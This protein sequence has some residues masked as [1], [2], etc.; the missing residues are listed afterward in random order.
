MIPSVD[1]VKMMAANGTW[2]AA[3]PNFLY[4]L[5]G[6][7]EQTL[8]GYRLE[9]NNPVALPL[10]ADV[11]MVFGSDNLPIGPMVG[12]YTAL[13]RKGSDGNGPQYSW[14]VKAEDKNSVEQ[15]GRAA[16]AFQISVLV[17]P[18]PLS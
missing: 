16:P 8:D 6:R 10:K 7:Y 3:Q 1:T 2:V 4:N 14:P 12:L 5:E 15:G 9:H 17:K 18:P 13:T 11:K